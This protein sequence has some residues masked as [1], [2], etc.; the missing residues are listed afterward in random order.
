MLIENMRWIE[1]H[2]LVSDYKRTTVTVM[3]VP[4][5][6]VIRSATI[7]QNVDADV[8]AAS[9]SMCFLLGVKIQQNKRSELTLIEGWQ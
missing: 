5:G 8:K 4:K 3:N 6:C 9:E 1:L 2:C 7:Y